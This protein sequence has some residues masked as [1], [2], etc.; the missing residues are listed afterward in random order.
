MMID[1]AAVKTVKKGNVTTILFVIQFRYQFYCSAYR[2]S[3]ALT[4]N[5][6]GRHLMKLERSLNYV[7]TSYK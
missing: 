4:M 5:A 3:W 2:I 1:A 7:Q 6:I